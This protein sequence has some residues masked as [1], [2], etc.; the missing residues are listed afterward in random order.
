MEVWEPANLYFE[1]QKY[2]PGDNLFLTFYGNLGLLGVVY[3]IYFAKLGQSLDLKTELF[4]YLFMFSFF[5][6]GIVA[7]SIDNALFC[8]FLGGFLGYTN[9]Q[10]LKVAVQTLG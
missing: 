1:L 4:Y 6:Y 5:A 8:L 9:N 10:K 7:S 2:N 3:L